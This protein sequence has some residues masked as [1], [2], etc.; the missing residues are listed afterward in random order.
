MLFDDGSCLREIFEQ[1][2]DGMDAVL[3]WTDKTTDL[4]M[5][6]EDLSACQRFGSPVDFRCEESFDTK[7]VDADNV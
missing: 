3:D 5:N 4:L 2:F 7:F 6:G 1:L